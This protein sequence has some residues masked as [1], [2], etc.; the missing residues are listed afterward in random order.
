MWGGLITCGGLLIRLLL[1]KNIVRPI[2]NRPQD[3]IL[4]HKTSHW[5]KIVAARKETK[6]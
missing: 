3:A 6:I 4:P 2:A 1:C 5:N